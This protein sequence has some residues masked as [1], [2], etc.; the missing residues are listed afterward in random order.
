MTSLN[1]FIK[2]TDG[3]VAMMFG[4][5]SVLLIM[6][7]GIAI[8]GSR[9]FA[10][11]SNVQNIA[12]SAALAGA[13][14]ADI[15]QDGRWRAVKQTIDFHVNALG[16]DVEL[17]N[18]NINFDDATESLTVQVDAR[19][20]LFFSSFFGPDFGGVS[21]QSSTSYA[22]ENLRPLSI[23]MVLDVSGSMKEITSRGTTRLDVVKE[24]SV[25]LFD[26]IKEGAPRPRQVRNLIRT[27]LNVY[28]NEHLRAFTIPPTQGWDDVLAQIQTLQAGGG[29]ASEDAVRAA[30]NAL[31]HDQDEPENN[32]RFMVFMTDGNNNQ[33]VSDTETIRLCDLAKADD[34][35]VFTVAFEAPANGQA[36][37]ENCASQ[38]SENH[39]FDANNAAQFRA[40]FDQIGA[41]IASL[42][43]RITN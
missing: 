31:R 26:A 33:A 13:H 7:A 21:G 19:Q 14:A 34:I 2:N 5:L 4:V 24:A 16:G 3:N 27:N 22:L 43:T 35:T 25:E 11:R 12:D 41:A 29:T 32:Q 23:A 37:L 15:E 9:L 36:L 10:L 20:D 39:Y 1:K 28:N 38:P 17:E 18:F 30:F 42:N 8:D 40:A 6:V